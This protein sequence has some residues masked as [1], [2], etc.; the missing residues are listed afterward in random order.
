MKHRA[1]FTF[2]FLAA[3]SSGQQYL[4]STI[5]GGSP[6]ITPAPA[7]GVSIGDPPRVAVDSAGN[8]Y[9]GGLHCIFR[10]DRS[11]SLTRI[12]GTGRAGLA[13]D[14]GLAVNAQLLFPDAIAIDAAGNIYFTERGANLI[15]KIATS[16]IISTFAGAGSA[17]YS[18]DGGPA[19]AAEFHTPT[20][21]AFDSSGNLYVA[22]TDNDVIRRIAANGTIT[23]VAGTGNRGYAGDG[24]PALRADLNSPEGVAL[25][26][27]GNLY[28]ADTFNNRIRVVSPAGIITTFAANGYPG[29]SGDNGPASDAALFFPVDVAAGG[30]GSVYIADLGNSRIRKVRLGAME[31]LAGNP[32]GGP[33]IDHSFASSARLSGPTGV[34]VDALGTVY[35]TEGSVGSG[36]GLTVGDYRVWKITTDDFLFVVAGNG[37]NSFSGDTGSAVRAQLN[38]PAGMA[39]DSAG[40]LYFADSENHRVRKISPAGIISTVAGNALP[41]FSGDGGPAALAEL[42]TP[43]AVALDS[44]GN[45][46][47]ADSANNRIRKVSPSGTIGTYAGNGNAALFGDGVSSVMAALHGPRGIA[48]DDSDIVYIA[49]TLNHRIRKVDNGGIIDS[50]PVLLNRPESLQVD[51][52][53]NLYIADRGT[54]N[55]RKVAPA[56]AVST[57]AG[58]ESSDPAG[59][60]VDAAGNLY[61]ADAV[62]NRVRRFAADG[63]MSVVAGSGSCCYAGDGGPAPGA[64]LNSPWGVAVDRSGNVYIADSRNNAIRLAF[65]GNS[66][67][68]IREVTNSASNLSGAVAPGEIVTIYGAGL[69]PAQ[70]TTTPPAGMSVLFNGAVARI[71]YA[72]A[73]QVAAVVPAI[74]LGS[75]AQIV[76][77][78]AG[79]ST[80]PYILSVAPAA[81]G[82]FTAD[83]SGGG[84]ALATNQD[85][86][87]NSAARPAAPGSRI[88]LFATGTGVPTLPLTLTIGGM[89]ATVLSSSEVSGGVLQVVALVPDGVHGIASP[90][91]LTAGGTASPPGPGIAVQ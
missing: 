83:S 79:Q 6:P 57:V 49:D 64:S 39:L 41:G 69:G 86:S 29:F 84:Q 75:S 62:G 71:L 51:A 32:G 90:V 19:L 43:T 47:I 16:G 33:A 1:L 23:T 88:T 5:A 3:L 34:A 7:T 72:S 85:G 37:N 31:T 70:L 25:D 20:G 52:A 17:G 12:A 68:F 78:Y 73:T 22:D 60:A 67:A 38:V 44:H 58:T 14:G 55:V 48:I 9:F 56:G 10:V 82:I 45:L 76:V 66:A 26:S 77:Q 4:V 24:Q 53:G 87:A 18:G 15:R 21:L 65:A 46:Y 2:F 42:H 59:L 91:V 74:G 27:S 89:A 61:V 11:G 13:G 54:H 36:S 8:I 40:N 81:P 35:F 63:T 50:L 30:D 28:I 80:S